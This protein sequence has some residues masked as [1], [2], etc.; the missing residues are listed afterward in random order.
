MRFLLRSAQ[1][2]PSA[3]LHSTVRSHRMRVP[4]SFSTNHLIEWPFWP[5]AAFARHECALPAKPSTALWRRISSIGQRL[6]R[7]FAIVKMNRVICKNL[8]VLVPLSCQQHDV[9]RARLFD[10]QPN[11]FRAVRF[12]HVLPTGP[13]H[14]HHNV[15]DDF[16]RVFLARIVAGQNRKVAKTSGNLSHDRPFGPVAR[17]AAAEYRDDSSF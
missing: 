8:V 6:S 16:Q 13:L 7:F 17:P 14:S 15:T 2:L 11:G 12:D 10:R 3:V 5:V 9:S 1:A 4:P